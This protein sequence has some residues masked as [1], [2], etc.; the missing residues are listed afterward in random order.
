MDSA[1]DTKWSN[2][3]NGDEPAGSGDVEAGAAQAAQD[4]EEDGE[5]HC[6]AE[7]LMNDIMNTGMMGALLGGFAL[8]TVQ[9][10]G[11]CS[12]EPD[13]DPT[14]ACESIELWIY[15]TGFIAVHACTCSAITSCLLYRIANALKED[16]VAAWK[17]DHRYILAMPMVKFAMGALS[18]LMSVILMSWRDLEAAPQ[19]QEI[20]MAIG[21][22][23]M[24][25]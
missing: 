12:S 14:D 15:M 7:Q 4:G 9:S 5:E 6:T 16:E 21:I 8:G 23:S 13:D 25:M 24:S 20:A 18:Y 17:T 3:L 22:M 11:P 1:E 10:G 2:P 19:T